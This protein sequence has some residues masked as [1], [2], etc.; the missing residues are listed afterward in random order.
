MLESPARVAMA[1]SVPNLRSPRPLLVAAFGRADECQ[2][3]DPDE[4]EAARA[5]KSDRSRLSPA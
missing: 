5:A 2:S 4:T 1:A 3:E